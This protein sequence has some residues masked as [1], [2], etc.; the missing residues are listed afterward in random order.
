MK[1]SLILAALVAFAATTAADAASLR[2]KVVRDR[3]GVDVL[4]VSVTPSGSKVYGVDI[5][6][7]SGSVADVVAP[8]GWVGVAA[9][10]HILFRTGRRPIAPGRTLT[11]RIYTADPRAP[12]KV[13]LRN[14]KIEPL[15]AERTL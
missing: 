8:K 9:A 6:D 7:A 11:F 12:L 14:R 3:H 4:V 10:D 1:R 5:V 2:R 15:G 13:R